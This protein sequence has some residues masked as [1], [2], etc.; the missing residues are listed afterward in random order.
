MDSKI[1]KAS[2]LF[3]VGSFG[4]AKRRGEGGNDVTEIWFCGATWPDGL[5]DRT[6]A[7]RTRKDAVSCPHRAAALLRLEDE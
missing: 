2:Q 7:H 3:R 4:T 1:T 5:N 6:C